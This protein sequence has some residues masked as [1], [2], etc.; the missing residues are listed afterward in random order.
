MQLIFEDKRKKVIREKE[1]I[2]FLSFSSYHLIAIS[3]RVKSEKQLGENALDGEDLT[4]QIGT[5]RTFPKL[6]SERLKDFPTAFSGG[7]QHNLLK[8]VYIL[9]FLKGKN[10]SIILKTDEQPN[11]A[12]FESLK[13][14]TL[15]LLEKSLTFDVNQQAED[16]D[17]RPCLTFVLDNLP[18]KATTPIITYSRRKRDSDDVKIITDGKTQ[19]NILRT[20]KHFLWRFAGSLFPKFSPRK[21]E[22]ETFTVNLLN[23]FHYKKRLKSF[24]CKNFRM[25]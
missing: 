25:V 15:N 11:T 7:R 21:T 6:N 10:H 4:I 9:T 8:T 3:A 14:Y 22:S 24:I 18:L 23:N 1:Q 5:D 2:N 17:R 19:K 13:V 20:I 12:T 16:G